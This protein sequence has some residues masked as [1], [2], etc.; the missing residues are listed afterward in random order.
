MAF[1]QFFVVLDVEAVAYGN[2]LGR[3]PDAR[4][5]AGD[6]TFDRFDG[7][8]VSSAPRL[9]SAGVVERRVELALG[10]FCPVPFRFAMT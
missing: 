2:G 7:Q 6:N 8:Q 10:A 3:V 5:G 1:F 9:C 4:Q